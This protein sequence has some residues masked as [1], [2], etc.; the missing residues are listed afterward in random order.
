MYVVS[1]TTPCGLGPCVRSKRVGSKELWLHVAY[2]RSRAGTLR[3]GGA[4]GMPFQGEKC[5]GG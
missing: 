2:V 5:G 4:H 1:R 3:M